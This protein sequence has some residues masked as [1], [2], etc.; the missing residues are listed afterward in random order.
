MVRPLPMLVI[1]NGAADAAQR[2][3]WIE[4]I[5]TTI[6]Q[7]GMVRGFTK[8]DDQPG[9]PEAAVESIRRG[10]IWPTPV[11]R[12]GLVNLMY[13][14]RNRNYRAAP[15]CQFCGP[16]PDDAEPPRAALEAAPNC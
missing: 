16:T 3:P 6:D 13:R 4:W 10:V 12:P 14:C 11:L 7:G 5:H 1:G 15:T 2:R 8:W 9:S